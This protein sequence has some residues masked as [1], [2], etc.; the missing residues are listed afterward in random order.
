MGGVRRNTIPSPIPFPVTPEKKNV[1]VIGRPECHRFTCLE[2]LGICC[3][4]WQKAD[5]CA[6]NYL[7]SFEFVEHFFRPFSLSKN[8]YS[9][10]PSDAFLLDNPAR[11]REMRFV[12]APERS[13]R[14]AGTMRIDYMVCVQ[15]DC[16]M[17]D[18]GSVLFQDE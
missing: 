6:S 4:A 18:L 16:D 15:V 17:G 8:R 12:P 2:F 5:L 1:P 10:R 7:S 11:V 9:V 3:L 14:N 13:F